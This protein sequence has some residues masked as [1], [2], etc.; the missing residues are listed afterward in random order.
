M[1]KTHIEYERSVSYSVKDMTNVKFWRF[2][3]FFFALH[4]LFFLF[5][6]FQIIVKDQYSEREI[7]IAGKVFSQEMCI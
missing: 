4:I 6:N 7:D 3:F 2:F 1:R 5:E